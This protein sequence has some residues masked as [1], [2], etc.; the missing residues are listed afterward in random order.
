MAQNDEILGISGHID[1]SDIEKSIQ[2]LI[3]NLDRIGVKT[4]ALSKK[5]ADS[6]N[7]IAKS[8]DDTATKQKR[9][10]EVLVSGMEEAKRALANYPEQLRLAKNEADATAQATTRL[11]TELSKLNTK[12]SEAVIGSKTYDELKTK[13]A[14]VQQQIENNNT[15]HQQQLASVQQMEAGYNGLVQLYG[16]ANVAT[17]A[18]AVA[19]GATAVAVG[20]E[21]AQHGANATE[22][23]KEALATKKTAE[24]SVEA[25]NSNEGWLNS[26]KEILDYLKQREEAYVRLRERGEDNQKIL[27]EQASLIST[28]QSY[29]KNVANYDTALGKSEQQKNAQEKIVEAVKQT[30]E[31]QKEHKR[32]IADLEA[33]LQKAQEEY[34]KMIGLSEDAG[35]IRTVIQENLVANQYSRGLI[36][37]EEL[38]RILEAKDRITQLKTELSQAKN[39][40]K[41]LSSNTENNGKSGFKEQWNYA[42][43][44]HD[45]IRALTKELREQENEYDKLASKSGFDDQSKKAQELQEKIS[46][47]KSEIADTKKEMNEDVSG[48]GGFLAKWK[49]KITDVLTGNGKFQDSIGSMKASLSGMLGPFTAATGGA[50]TFAKSLWAIAATP[51]GAILS[52]IVI[53]LK[54]VHMWFTKSAEGQ[55]AFAKISA[56]VGS[57]LSSI[58]DIGVKLGSYLFNAFTQPQSAVRDFGLNLVALVVEPL[59]VILNLIKLVT[60][61]IGALGNIGQAVAAGDW[62]EFHK[63]LSDAKKNWNAM[64]DAFNAVG[65]SMAKTIQNSIQG[66]WNGLRAAKLIGTDAARA[67]SNTDITKVGSNFI[68]KAFEEATLAGKQLDA[69]KQLSEAKRDE[70]KLEIDIAR[71]R[72]KIY[73]LTG[74]EK[75]AQIEKV[76]N[77]L[78]EKYEPQIAAQQTLLQIQQRRNKLH[79]VSL[80]QL[81]AERE[82]QGAVYALQAQQASSTRMLVRMQQANL[83][84]MANAGKKDARQQQQIDSANTAYNDIERKNA[85]TR[86][87]F[88]QD[89]EQK[90]ADA[91]IAAMKEGAEKVLAEKNK[92]LE[93]ELL[94]IDEQRKAAVEA[95]RARQKAE[96]EAREKVIKAHGGKAEQ[97][98]DKKIDQSQIDD[99]NRQFDQLR[100]LTVSRQ[101]AD[102]VQQRIQSMRDYLREYGT[103]EQKRL[104]ITQEYEKKIARAR[105][106]GNEG[107]V[108]KLQ[109]ER[110]RQ[111]GSAKAQELSRGIDFSQ[112]FEGVGTIVKSIAEETYKRVQQ[113]KGTDEYKKSTPESKKAITDLEARLIE[114][115][116]AGTA[117]P[118]S[119]STWDD[120][121][122]AAE[123]YDAALKKLQWKTQEHTAAVNRQ[124]EAQKRY[125][126]VMRDANATLGERLAAEENLKN[127]NK[128]VAETAKG[129]KDAQAETENAGQDVQNASTKAAKGLEDF[130]T[131][132]SQITSGTLSGF[133]NGVSNIIASLTKKTSDDMNGL[134]GVIGEKAGGIIGAI[135]SI[136]DMLGT[137]P[138]E[139]FEGLLDGIASVIRE[140]ISHIPEIIASIIKGVG[141][142][143]A[144]IGEGVL[145]LFG[146]SLSSSNRA[147]V[148]QANKRLENATMVNTEAINRLTDAMKSSS[149]AEAVKQW[150]QAQKLMQINE[151]NRMRQMSN[152]AGMHDGGHSLW[153][154]FKD[155][156]GAWELTQKIYN[157]VG[158]KAWDGSYDVG[159]LVH[160]LTAEDWN[161]VLREAPE[162]MTR[163]GEMIAEAEDDGNYNGMFQDILDFAK[164][165]SKEAYD[166][167]RATLQEAVTGVSFDSFKDKFKS[168]LMD[169]KKDAKGFSDDLSEMLMESFLNSAIENEF[170]DRLRSLYDEWE[171]ALSNDNVLTD[172]EVQR[173]QRM[174]EQ[175]ANEM[176][177]RRNQIAQ[178][179]GYDKVQQ[180]QQSA[181]FN[182]AQNITYEQADTI[183]GTTTAILITQEQSLA[184]QIEQTSALSEI[185]I[186][187][188]SV[189]M[190]AHAMA[191]NIN[192]MVETQNRMNNHLAAI[193]LNTNVLPEMA[194]ELVKIRKKVDEQ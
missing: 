178:V 62:D 108:L 54:A 160:D 182:S 57:L 164:E 136:I 30:S 81:A 149:P 3:S 55:R 155:I 79:S 159:S 114:R 148:E 14:G 113:Y 24:M 32:S 90:I 192:A 28:I 85:I 169:M 48:V 98:D 16:A 19:H 83:R 188:H 105:A 75:D 63:N 153:Y 18:N 103:I 21:A 109:S 141:G 124:E 151:E 84:S 194:E 94:Q 157:L 65:E 34:R 39:E 46:K 115:G 37:E 23:E 166:E 80:E 110:D 145:G 74:K 66:V 101:F 33:E 93:R 154:D 60:N 127:A 15:L 26:E 49:N 51:I 38:T 2:E 82:A 29:G 184:Q 163:L 144:G 170:G 12:F 36:T 27:A 189:A 41:Q 13:I 102:D 135:L 88:Q 175:I 97:W 5:M 11:E 116:G 123:K 40:A 122:K 68:S 180:D 95:E 71:E 22:I 183:A 119:A 134:I 120:I 69:Q 142:I 187:T 125:D 185:Q 150:Q 7:E 156:G 128:E 43:E 104:A 130:N 42:N 138:V 193:E 121:T 20:V 172:A 117:S 70:K 91:R 31:A 177:E 190:D 181:T 78:R 67:I 53:G 152:N 137:K 131:V 45:K 179:T 61:S 6:L 191:E 173:L 106:L 9:A 99:I 133:A 59:K 73:T 96:F 132:L 165:Y 146:I 10:T 139:F 112:M 1:I 44:L 35:R 176:L 100:G 52:A 72:E 25:K 58:T 50:M 92:E 77:M 162:L 129:K 64:G 126:A 171:A 86:A 87:K 8:S 47:L 174:E 4:D 140:V 143:V 118:F 168:S 186:D 158:K 56:F 89:M 76:K 111:I 17:T 167:L 147:E 107:E 161:K